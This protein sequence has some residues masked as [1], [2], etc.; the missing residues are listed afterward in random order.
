M[1]EEINWGVGSMK[2]KKLVAIMF[3]FTLVIAMGISG[4][5]N[6][7]E[8]DWEA[9]N[10]EK[11]DIKI[12]YEKDEIPKV[13]VNKKDSMIANIEND[14]VRGMPKV[15]AEEAK[16]IIGG[17]YITP[18][19]IPEGFKLYGIYAK[20]EEK[21]QGPTAIQ[22]WYDPDKLEVISVVQIKETNPQ[23][24]TRNDEILFSGMTEDGKSIS[25]YYPWATYRTQMQFTKKGMYVQGYI[26]LNDDKNRN[27]YNKILNSL[28]G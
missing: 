18:K 22:I 2:E 16:K 8:P 23:P 19:Y 7:K 13:E 12:E 4:C 20:A 1:Y 21:Y 25:D 17:K 24:D 15:T 26:L 14:F 9:I 3:C 10:G 11:A 5:S 28:K 6:S 27:E